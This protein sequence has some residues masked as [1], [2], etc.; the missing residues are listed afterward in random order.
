ME[1]TAI[2][3][4]VITLFLLVI[5]VG[6][7]TVLIYKIMKQGSVAAQASQPEI[8]KPQFHPE[9]LERIKQNYKNNPNK[10]ALFCPNHPDEPG[11]V[12]CAIF[13]RLYCKS[14]I[15]PYR[16]MHFCKEHLPLVMRYE[17]DEVLTLKTSTT[18]PE[19]GVKLYEIKKELFERD[20]IPTFVET[21]YKIN[22]DQDHIETYLVLF[23]IRENVPDLKSKLKEFDSGI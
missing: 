3:L 11:E 20:E 10:T 21:H 5:I 12:M 18:D 15:K 9:I 13:D 8:P 7:L 6:F 22:V 1:K 2:L 17:W 19:Q 23:G 4:I 14:C 16:T